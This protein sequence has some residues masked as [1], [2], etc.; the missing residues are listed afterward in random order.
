M[1]DIN[2]VRDRRASGSFFLLC[3]CDYELKMLLRSKN[4]ARNHVSLVKFCGKA[5]LQSHIA[6]ISH[7]SRLLLFRSDFLLEA[8]RQAERL[9]RILVSFVYIFLSMMLIWISSGSYMDKCLWMMHP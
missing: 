4:S 1:K 6:E 7:V 5:V 9:V 8:F 2:V 3:A